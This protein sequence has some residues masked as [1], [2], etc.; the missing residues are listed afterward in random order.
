M[1]RL[2]GLHLVLAVAPLV[3]GCSG[4]NEGSGTDLVA[5][6]D[7]TGATPVAIVDGSPVT[8]RALRY[9]MARRGG[10]LPGRFETIEEKEA[11]LND[12]VD[13]HVLAAHARRRGLD[14]EPEVEDAI[15]RLLAD[16]FL[17][18]IDRTGTVLRP[19]AD[20]DIRA[21]YEAHHADYRVPERARGS[22]LFL[23]IP[24]NAE[25]GRIEAIR[26]KARDLRRQASREDAPPDT[27]ARLVTE[28]S[29][30]PT[31]R[32]RHG[33]IGWL[34][35]NAV[36]FQVEAAVITA[37]F[38]IKHVGSIGPIVETPNGFYLVQL[39]DR[40]DEAVRP[41]AEIESTIRQQI[42]ADRA[43]RARADRIT[44]LSKDL[45]IRVDRERLETIG[46]APRAA[47]AHGMPPAF[48]VEQ[49][50]Q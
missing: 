19:V 15:T 44:A 5:S 6:R 17:A 12:L 46:P 14:R 26:E 29:N 39:T 2:S 18:E 21:F 20:H 22:I 9:E 35:R 33:D 4:R 11:V 24:P 7:D 50:V 38:E 1:L 42:A 31:S 34:L 40:A 32:A 49:S 10:E 43:R 16:R 3:S 30:E 8:A 37:L 28:N 36:T 25:R 27:F 13:L 45:D 47:N 41:L 48:P 23:R